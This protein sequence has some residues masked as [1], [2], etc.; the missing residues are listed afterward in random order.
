MAAAG[1]IEQ[2]VDGQLQVYH[3]PNA[4]PT[5]MI[6]SGAVIGIQTLLLSSNVTVNKFLGIPFAVN[7]PERFSLPVAVPKWSVPQKAQAFTSACMQ[8]FSSGP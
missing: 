6:D 8:Q 1:W 3:G 5:A 4:E 2:V 7:P